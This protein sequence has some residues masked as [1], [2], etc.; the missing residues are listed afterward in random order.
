MNS[1]A[2]I[3][4]STA[5]ANGINI[6]RIVDLR[7]VRVPWWWRALQLAASASRSI[8]VALRQSRSRRALYAL[9]DRTLTDIGIPRSEVPSA[10]RN[11]R[12]LWHHPIPQPSAR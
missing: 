10:V 8:A 6:Q 9:S 4:T 2:T 7:A 12:P 3:M 1:K 5:M 11:G